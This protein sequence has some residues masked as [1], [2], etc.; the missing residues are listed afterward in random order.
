MCSV[1]PS[2]TQD[3]AGAWEQLALSNMGGYAH[4]VRVHVAPPEPAAKA[5][6][7][8]CWHSEVGGWG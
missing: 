6:A 4:D 3:K 2:P 1:P 7:E 5:F 8:L